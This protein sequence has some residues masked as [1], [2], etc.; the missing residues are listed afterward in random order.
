MAR[1]LVSAP[2]YRLPLLHGGCSPFPPRP[3]F[4][5]PPKRLDLAV[6]GGR[7]TCSCS[8]PPLSVGDGFPAA[9]IN[10][11]FLRPLASVVYWKSRFLAQ[12]EV[13]FN[14]FF[15]RCLVEWHR[16]ICFMIKN[17]G[18]IVPFLAD[19]GCL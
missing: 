16:K 15:F 13:V 12:I 8:A 11:G 18:L 7:I 17:C 4:P 1:D 2:N 6:P 14:L 5:A 19:F 9:G 3:S 10:V